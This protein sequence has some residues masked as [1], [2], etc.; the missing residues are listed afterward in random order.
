MSVSLSA[1]NLYVKVKSVKQE[2]LY[3]AQQE[4]ARLGYKAQVDQHDSWHRIYAGAFRSQKKASRALAKIRKYISPD[5]YIIDFAIDPNDSASEKEESQK[6]EKF[7]IGFTAGKTKFSVTEDSISEDLPLYFQL[8]DSSINYGV[9]F[10]YY[11]TKNIFATLNYQFS[12]MKHISFNHAFSTLNYQLDGIYSISPYI[13]LVGGYG[14]M[15]WKSSPIDMVSTT[16]TTASFIGGIQVGTE[17]AINDEL[18]TYIFY[19]Y[20]KT[21]YASDVSLD[22]DTKKIG[23]NTDQNLNIGIKYNF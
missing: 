10:G 5:A 19:R 11:F 9:E 14:I 16:E 21:D 8:E 12:D 17:I 3:S 7:F 22:A 6:S 2:E 18:S 20:I 23:Y 4:L 15:S 13:G 1:V